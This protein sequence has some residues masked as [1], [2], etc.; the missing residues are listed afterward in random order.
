LPLGLDAQ[1]Y[2]LLAVAIGPA[3]LAVAVVAIVWRW[4]KRSEAAVG[5][6]GDPPA[7]EP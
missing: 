1:E 2:S 6:G 4:A 7:Q 5:G 3:L